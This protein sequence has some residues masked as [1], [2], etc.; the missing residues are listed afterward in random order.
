M[1]STVHEIVIKEMARKAED[2]HL[3]F[4]KVIAVAKEIAEENADLRQ[5]MRLALEHLD[6][7]KWNHIGAVLLRAL[8]D[9]PQPTPMK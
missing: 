1:L 2:A 5:A 4:L 8:G 7:E 3:D 6:N 9:L